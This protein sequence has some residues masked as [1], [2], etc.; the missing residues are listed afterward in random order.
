MGGSCP[1]PLAAHGTFSNGVLQLDAAWGDVQAQA[2]L[3]RATASAAVTTL[4]HAEAL[5]E[6]VAERLR[7]GGARKN[8]R[9]PPKNLM[10]LW[11]TRKKMH[12]H[13][14]KH[15]LMNAIHNHNHN[16]KPL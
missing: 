15:C 1:M 13:M 10:N 12:K 11:I 4:V 6:A 5:G 9:N 7:P 14:H 8:T 3:V 2:P 16:I